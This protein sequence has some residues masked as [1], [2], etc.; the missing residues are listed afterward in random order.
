[1][2]EGENKFVDA[3]PRVSLLLLKPISIELQCQ[4]LET[5]QDLVQATPSLCR[6]EVEREDV[7]PRYAPPVLVAETD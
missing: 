2:E 7:S 1:M 4:I 5:M 6:Q 3:Q